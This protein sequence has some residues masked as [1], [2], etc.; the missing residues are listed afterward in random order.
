MSCESSILKSLALLK[1]ENPVVEIVAYELKT[2]IGSLD[3]FLGKT[4]TDDI[5]NKVFSSFC[6]GK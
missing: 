5:L 3:S 1:K 2:A 6:V 4:T